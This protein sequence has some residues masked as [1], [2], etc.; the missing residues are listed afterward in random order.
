MSNGELY[1]TAM[2]SVTALFSDQSVSQSEC[3]SNL[4]TLIDEIEVLIS[5]LSDDEGD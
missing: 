4:E 3:K 1:E 5:T 2:E